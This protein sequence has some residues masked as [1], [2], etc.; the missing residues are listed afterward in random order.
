MAISKDQEELLSNLDIIKELVFIVA[1][2]T[3]HN[4]ELVKARKILALIE[5][6]QNPPPVVNSI[7]DYC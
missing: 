7:L 4:N 6:I 1:E 3:N 5:T 2:T